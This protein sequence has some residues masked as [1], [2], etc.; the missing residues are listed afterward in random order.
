MVSKEGQVLLTSGK[1]EGGR[2]ESESSG[3]RKMNVEELDNTGVEG[4]N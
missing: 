3:R 1:D 4:G 2:T